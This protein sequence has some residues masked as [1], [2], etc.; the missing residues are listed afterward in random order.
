MKVKKWLLSND[1]GVC[2]GCR[3]NAEQGWIAIDVPYAP[4][5]LAP[6]DHAGC[7]CDAAYR[8]AVP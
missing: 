7:R 6:L 5:A 2:D 4:G 8:R 3:A 1:P